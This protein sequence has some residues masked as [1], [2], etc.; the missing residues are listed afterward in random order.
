MSK[1]IWAAE[2]LID[3]LKKKNIQSWLDR[4]GGMKLEGIGGE[5]C[6][7]NTLYRILK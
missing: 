5:I 3:G 1:N 7:Q 6:D 4:E 2:I